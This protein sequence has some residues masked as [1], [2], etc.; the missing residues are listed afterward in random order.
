MAQS[1]AQSVPAMLTYSLT[2]ITLRLMLKYVAGLSLRSERIGHLQILCSANSASADGTLT[3]LGC[4]ASNM[5]TCMPM[6]S[7][8]ASISLA[9]WGEDKIKYCLQNAQVENTILQVAFT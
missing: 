2:L 6:T 8:V 1:V 4:L 7:V 3:T 5:W 9:I